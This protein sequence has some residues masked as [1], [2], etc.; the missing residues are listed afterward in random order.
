M[1]RGAARPASP[2]QSGFSHRQTDRLQGRVTSSSTAAPAFEAPCAR[3][4]AAS[5]G[6]T[7]TVITSRFFRS[8]LHEHADPAQRLLGVAALAPEA[9][10]LA[11]LLTTDPAPEV[12]AA[13]ARRCSRLSELA[14]AWHAEA[15]PD[16]HA[17][18]ASVLGVV[19]A[20]TPDAE[21]AR[22][23]LG[24]ENCSDAIRGEV[25]RRTQDGERRRA[26]VAAMHDEHLLVELALTAPLAETR[27]AAAE[28]VHT[29]ENLQRLFDAARDLDRDRG[30]ARLARQR[31]DAMATQEGRAAEADAILG[32]LEALVDQPGPVLSAVVE[33]NRRWE[34][35]DLRDDP[36]RLARSQSAR[37]ALQ[38]RFDR[39][40][41]AH[42]ARTRFATRL[43][44]WIAGLQNP[45][46]P[47]GYAVL[48]D[49]LAQLRAQAA[50]LSDSDAEPALA[51]AEQ[52]IA[53]WED[54]RLAQASAEAL[55]IEAEALAAGT[56]VDA[57]G[58]P[59]R[60]QG[61]DRAIRTP[62]LTQRFETALIAI[63]QR[64]L[65]LVSAEQQQANANRQRVH[66]A[67]HTAEQALSAGELHA[68]RAAVDEIR[69]LKAS[70]GMLPKPTTQRVS[71]VVQQLT[72]LERWE[73]FGQHQARIQLCE[74]AEVLLTQQE[75]APRV[76]AEVKK[77]RAEWKT[78]DQQ[79]A[80][81][82]KALWERFDRACEKA[83]APAARQFA[84]ASAR[85]KE[86]RRKRDE[87]IA[88]AEIHAPTLLAE[89]R[90]WRA[91]ERWIRET[92]HTWRDGDLG[93]VEPGTWKTL[94]ARLRAVLA[95]LR[96]A[97]AAVR[98]EAKAARLA[99]I[100]E[101]TAFAARAMERDT[102]AQLRAIQARWQERAKAMPLPQRDE[103]PLW[104]AF[105]AACD[106][107]FSAR[108][109]KRK[110]DDDR[111]HEGRRAQEQICRELDA[112]AQTQDGD[113]ALIRRSLRGL[114]DQW[115]KP[116]GSD[117]GAGALEARFRK[118]R[119]AV[120]DLL[121]ARARSREAAVWQVLAAKESLCESLDRRVMVADGSA[122]TAA[123]AEEAW[124]AAGP[125]PED[126]ERKL[127]ARRDA[128]LQAL[129]DEAAAARYRARINDGAGARRAAIVELEMLAELESPAEFQPQR[130]AL[131]VQKLKAR[132]SGGGADAGGKE[133]LRLLDWC[134]Q[135]GVC[136][137]VDR[138]RIEAVFSAAARRH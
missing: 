25:V 78:L 135:P 119:T 23:F 12:R 103:R 58:L 107:V 26:A 97:L 123:T 121:K 5:P 75:D 79:H 137:D 134:A 86:A 111:K 125:L 27:L 32:A 136:D 62:E 94:D 22:A 126:W 15:D 64:R 69:A 63:E 122:A 24:A 66:G 90:D 36:A 88:M 82:P 106:A 48:R 44:E 108:D 105:R 96:D 102:P 99:L 109:S 89:P 19:L 68:A 131:Q 95:P 91:I 92:E 1:P 83:Y 53:E 7:P 28:R 56:G 116:L 41:E 72:E 55:V 87:F 70:I 73:S 30:V 124:T 42:R 46:V 16:V 8:A 132:F 118:S 129:A 10:E 76:A 112:L 2:V 21:A 33:L 113:D 133:N 9:D 100:A 65:A 39:E 45:A 49:E 74:R 14:S 80:G 18:L 37:E 71:R 120:E 77:L 47:E 67:L 50:E 3:G 4:S 43:R 52:R 93:S 51:H 98:G 31:I 38:A 13:A 81:V 138:R 29:R 104:E 127:V 85:R 101:A 40:H 128:A 110:E 20:D 35:L 115:K 61:L 6:P 57:A 60:W 117:P 114:V 130:L 59:E 17:A 84:E 11:L 54:A 34:A